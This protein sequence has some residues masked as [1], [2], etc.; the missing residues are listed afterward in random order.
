MKK[1]HFLLLLVFVLALG[2]VGGALAYYQSTLHVQNRLTTKES[3]V[4]MKEI[5]NPADQWVPG[6]TKQKEV[7]FGNVGLVDQVIRFRVIEKWSTNS[8]TAWTYQGSYSPP[9]VTIHYTA[10]VAADWSEID[11]WYYY[12]KPLKPGGEEPRVIDQLSFS[13]ALANGGYSS[14]DDFSDKRYSLTVEMEALDVNSAETQAAWQMTFT[15]SGNTLTWR[16]AS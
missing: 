6:E 15:Q 3:G 2:M 5:F 12:K 14:V 9:P 1:R 13:K 10:A 7:S 8:G 11:G 16:S 4:T